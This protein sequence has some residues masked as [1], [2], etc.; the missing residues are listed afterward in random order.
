MATA[1]VYQLPEPM[2]NTW[3]GLWPSKVCKASA[4]TFTCESQWSIKSQVLLESEPVGIAIHIESETLNLFYFTL[5]LANFVCF[6]FLIF[7]RKGCLFGFSEKVSEFFQIDL[8]I[9][10]KAFQ[11]YPLCMNFFKRFGII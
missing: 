2:P 1:L 10:L 8:I 4:V 3:E 5:C 6:L 11:F 7:G 9:K